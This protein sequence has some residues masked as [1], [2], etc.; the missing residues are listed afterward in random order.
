MFRFYK[1]QV[2]NNLRHSS[3]SIRN[4]K[5]ESTKIK[6]FNGYYSQRNFAQFT[7]EPQ[8]EQIKNDEIEITD[9]AVEVFI[10]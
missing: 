9:R 10:L 6:I 1:S 8:K 5:N 2:Y 3:Y 4:V 7:Q